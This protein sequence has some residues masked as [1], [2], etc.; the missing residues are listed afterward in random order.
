MQTEQGLWARVE[1]REE[2]KVARARGSVD[3]E[4]AKR[5]EDKAV[6]KAL[7][8]VDQ[9]EG[10]VMVPADKARASQQHKTQGHGEYVHAMGAAAVQT[11]PRAQ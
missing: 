11:L 9:E 2:A 8:L 4:E 3:K 7:A 10:P 6:P 5:T 1:E